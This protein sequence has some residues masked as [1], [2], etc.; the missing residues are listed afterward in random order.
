MRAR[1]VLVGARGAGK[2]SVGPVLAARLGVSFVDTDRLVE[3][4]AGRPLGEVWAAGEFRER[5]AR[6]LEQALAT[7][8]AVVAAGGGAVLWAGFAAAVKGWTVVWLD[9]APEVLAGRIRKDPRER[10]SLT[11]RPAAEEIGE[12]ARSRAHLYAAVA[13]A[14]VATD[15]LAVDAV[16]EEIE[17]VVHATT[18]GKAD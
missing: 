17:R 14:R 3:E 18:R 15:R 10:P 16:A 9:A 8:S 4:Q 5:E 13:S 7:P 1:V 11:G 2:S 12:V 6:A